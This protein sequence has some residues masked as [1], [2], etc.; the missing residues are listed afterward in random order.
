MFGL[1]LFLR[2]QN[3]KQLQRASPYSA[4]AE[5]ETETER[6]ATPPAYTVGMLDLLT[7]C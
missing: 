7:I 4:I 6:A 1:A 3:A 5:T 2:V